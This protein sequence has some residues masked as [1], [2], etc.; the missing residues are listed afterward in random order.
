MALL[1]FYFFEE[2]IFRGLSQFPPC[3]ILYTLNNV[4]IYLYA[5]ADNI[6]VN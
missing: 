5:K 2:I 4:T 3:K 6:N 1:S